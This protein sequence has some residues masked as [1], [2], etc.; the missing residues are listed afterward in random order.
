MARRASQEINASSMADI[1]FL[2]LI[3]F[4]VTTTM[5]VDSGLTRILP[6]PPDPEAPIPDINKR[7]VFVVLVNA[8]DQ[9]L[10]AGKPGN[11]ESLRQQTKEFIT[12]PNN[13]PNL[14]VNEMLS[15]KIINSKNE[16]KQL[17][18][19]K[20]A[21]DLLGDR[22]VSKGIISLQNDRGTSY[23]M[24]IKVQNELAAAVDELRNELSKEVFGMTF[25]KLVE[26]KQEDKVDVIRT[27]IPMQVSEAEPK[28][29]GGSK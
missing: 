2:L 8:A 4:L 18:K 3:F 28:D 26:L 17:E 5:D 13:N 25:N 10:I 22:P 6:P 7:N 20:A 24:Y 19:Y 21:F 16:G 15:D 1:A 12:N 9:L 14:S 27:V 11:I 23:K 29:I